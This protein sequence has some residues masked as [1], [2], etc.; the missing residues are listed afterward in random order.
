MSNMKNKPHGQTVSVCLKCGAVGTHQT[1]DCK[2][3]IPS[4]KS[5]EAQIQTRIDFALSHVPRGWEKDEFGYFQSSSKPRIN[6]EADQPNC[7]N[8][9]NF[10]HTED[11]CTKPSRKEI[12]LK[13]GESLHQ[14]GQTA[15][16]EREEIVN[17]IKSEYYPELP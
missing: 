3:E 11:K 6:F 10:G 13:F 12:H 15:N 5:L 16:E 2:E 7:S 8:C 14:T 9:G 4:I 17:L 1:C